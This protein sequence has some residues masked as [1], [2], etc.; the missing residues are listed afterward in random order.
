LALRRTGI[1]TCLAFAS[2]ASVA[3]A[4]DPIDG[5]VYE[6]NLS[7]PKSDVTITLKVSD[8]GRRVSMIRLSHRPVFCATNRRKRP[9]R[10]K[11]ARITRMGTFRTTTR[12][13]A[14]NG[15]RANQMKGKLSISGRFTSDGNVTGTVRSKWNAAPEPGLCD[16]KVGFLA[17]T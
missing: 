9:V 10:F 5:G 13:M 4:A 14:T 12:S 8:N 2:L 1:A 15:P 7:A 16:G 11:P 3:L 6:G 17:G